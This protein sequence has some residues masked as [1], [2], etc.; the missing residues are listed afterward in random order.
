MEYK[1]EEYVNS[2]AT[3]AV[4]MPSELLM[5][6]LCN[7][8]TSIEG[9]LRDLTYLG[10]DRE[11]NA[12]ADRRIYVGK[13][14]SS[15]VSDIWLIPVIGNGGSYSDDLK[16]QFQS[17]QQNAGDKNTREGTSKEKEMH[18]PND[19]EISVG[20]ETRSENRKGDDKV[21]FETESLLKSE[22]L[23]AVEAFRLALI[24]ENLLPTRFDDQYMM[25][26]F[27]K[28][29]KFDVEKSKS[30]WVNMLQWRQDFGTDAI[31]EDFNF[32]ELDEVLKYHCH[33]HHGVDKDGRPIYIER[34][35]KVDPSK[36]MQVTTWDRIVKYHVQDF[37]KRVLMKFPACS[38]SAKRHIDSITVILDVQGVEP[39]KFAGSI[40]EVMDKMRLIDTNYYPET[41]HR[42]FIVNSG[43][44]F[45]MAW[46]FFCKKYIDSTTLSK[47]QVLGKKY[48]HKLLEIIDKSEL[49]EFLGGSCTC[50]DQ[51]GCLRS[52]KG[53]W[54]DPNVLEMVRGSQAECST[55]IGNTSK[56]DGT[57]TGGGKLSYPQTN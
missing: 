29:R 20:K 33:A 22:E 38:I 44:V 9:F 14:L 47:I 23:K 10:S 7:I 52:N 1:E 27:L 31:L 21:S 16:K 26:R 30:M 19:L 2:C 50:M 40:N 34:I 8:Q 15:I 39:K 53:P 51:G 48:Q 17:D 41:L 6:A 13:Q 57:T 49:P 32:P 12:L 56:S 42:M 36:L 5:A 28:A 37:E 25:L 3:E 4:E 18:A 54:N 55:Q 11:R 46:N 24:K 43:P 45:W 35:G